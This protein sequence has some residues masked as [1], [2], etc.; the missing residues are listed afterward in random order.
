MLYNIDTGQIINNQKGGSSFSSLGTGAKNI[1]SK[2]TGKVAKDL[3]TKAS[4]KAIEESSEQ[5]GIKVGQM[6]GEKIHDNFG[7]KTTK[8]PVVQPHD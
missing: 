1:G 5:I 4:T 2:L 3:A 8:Q 6:A 7:K